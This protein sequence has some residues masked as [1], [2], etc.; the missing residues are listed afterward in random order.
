MYI[1]DGPPASPVVGQTW[2][3][4]DTGNSFI[5]YN[6]GNSTQWVPSHVGALPGGAS[7]LTSTDPGP[8]GVMISAYHN[9]PQQKL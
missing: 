1:G 2:F 7:S 5:Y 3:E 8:V 6:D 9:S 4:S